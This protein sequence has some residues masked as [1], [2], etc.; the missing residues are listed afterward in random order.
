[1]FL[2]ATMSTLYQFKICPPVFEN[3]PYS[4]GIVM[5]S[6]IIF[7]VCWYLDKEILDS[8]RYRRMKEMG[9]AY[10]GFYLICQKHNLDFDTSPPSEKKG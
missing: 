8:L 10:D 4:W 7:G 2:H 9:L 5:I 1:M 6:G 3:S